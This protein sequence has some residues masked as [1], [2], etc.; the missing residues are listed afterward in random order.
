MWKTILSSPW[1]RL[2]RRHVDLAHRRQVMAD[3]S[4]HPHFVP[5]DLAALGRFVRQREGWDWGS[6]K[7][8][9]ELSDFSQ[10]HF[11]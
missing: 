9:E 2:H 8:Q 5:C 10:D 1:S 7:G 6:G 4:I 3:P 11:S